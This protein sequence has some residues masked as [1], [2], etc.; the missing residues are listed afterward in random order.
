MNITVM[1]RIRFCAGHRLLGH[2]G[3]CANFHGHS[4]AVDFY[5]SPLG[6]N[7]SRVDDVGRVIDFAEL[8]SRLKGWIDE[9]WDHG[10][11]LSRDDENGI[12]AMQSVEP[13]KLFL[14]ASNPTAENMARY[15]LEE[16]CPELLTPCSVEAVRIDLWES[17]ETRAIVTSRSGVDVGHFVAT[18]A[19][20]S[21]SIG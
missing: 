12:A 3:K 18:D 9:H 19:S 5:V 10:F 14:L 2:E 21:H 1:R 11:L 13:S 4:Y 16:V 6:E 20:L 7:A 17:E 8:K 15:L